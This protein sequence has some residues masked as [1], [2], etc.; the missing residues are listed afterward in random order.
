MRRLV[1]GARWGHCWR[2]LRYLVLGHLP[3]VMA[4]VRAQRIFIRE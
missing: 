3:E 1:G 4:L 2:C